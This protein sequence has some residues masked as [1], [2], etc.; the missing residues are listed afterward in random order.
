MAPNGGPRETTDHNARF[1]DKKA[2]NLKSLVFFASLSI[3]YSE[4]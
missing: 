3:R 2:P 1:P 4:P